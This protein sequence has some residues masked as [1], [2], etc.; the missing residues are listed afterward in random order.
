MRNFQD[1]FETRKRSFITAFSTCITVLLIYN[2]LIIFLYTSYFE[3]RN[4]DEI[5]YIRQNGKCNTNLYYKVFLKK[6]F[7]ERKTAL[8]YMEH[9]KRKC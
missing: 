7:L 8:Y 4:T 3:N 9:K 5:W 2:I 6:L 1:T